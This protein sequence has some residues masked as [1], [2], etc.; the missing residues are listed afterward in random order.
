MGNTFTLG[1]GPADVKIKPSPGP[2]SLKRLL[3]IVMKNSK[4]Y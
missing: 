4:V 2:L 3:K 1:K